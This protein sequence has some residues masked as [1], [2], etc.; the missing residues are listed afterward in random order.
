MASS[1]KGVVM[2]D[3]EG[4]EG[5]IVIGNP[6]VIIMVIMISMRNMTMNIIMEPQEI[7]IGV[8]FCIRLHYSTDK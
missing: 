6:I 3:I 1:V 4:M 5:H 8:Y 7:I 2:E